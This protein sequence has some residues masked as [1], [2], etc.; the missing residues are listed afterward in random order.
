MMTR[1]LTWST[2]PTLEKL[3]SLPKF[4]TSALYTKSRASARLIM[5]KSNDIQ[6]ITKW[7]ESYWPVI[8]VSNNDHFE[9]LRLRLFCFR[10]AAEVR[11]HG[12]YIQKFAYMIGRNLGPSGSYSHSVWLRSKIPGNW[13]IERNK[14]LLI[15]EWQWK[16]QPQHPE[17]IV[18]F[19][20]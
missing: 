3:T 18:V 1:A 4:R 9:D 5:F 16:W 12:T 11:K 7:F 13:P 19:A 20:S 2:K 6:V 15:G 14:L 10:I 17:E 8:E